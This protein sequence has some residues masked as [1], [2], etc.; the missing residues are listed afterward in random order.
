MMTALTSLMRRDI[1][2]CMF[3]TRARFYPIE[4]GRLS[5]APLDHPRALAHFDQPAGLNQSKQS[6]D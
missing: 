2:H 4:A 1:T 6:S 3:E 5:F